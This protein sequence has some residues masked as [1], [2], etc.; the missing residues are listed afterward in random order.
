MKIGFLR[1]WRRPAGIG[2][3][4][5]SNTVALRNSGNVNGRSAKSWLSKCDQMCAIDGP[6]LTMALRDMVLG[7]STIVAYQKGLLYR[8]GVVYL[9]KQD[10]AVLKILAKQVDSTAFCQHFGIP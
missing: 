5:D 7:R 6:W 3:S 9:S 1:A 4:H 2:R 8:L 10:F